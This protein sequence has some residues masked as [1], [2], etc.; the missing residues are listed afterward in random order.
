[1][2][3]STTK[4]NP[5]FR[6][7]VE[8]SWSCLRNKKLVG[9]AKQKKASGAHTYFN[10]IWGRSC[11]ICL[12]EERNDAAPSSKPVY[13]EETPNNSSERFMQ[14]SRYG[15]NTSENVPKTYRGRFYKDASKCNFQNCIKYKKH[16]QLFQTLFNQNNFLIVRYQ[17]SNMNHSKLA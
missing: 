13:F 10:S 17:R 4:H 16:E 1:M 12:L 11:E 8:M 15:Q 3:N 14:I 7:E 5:S 6:S 2:L 9:F